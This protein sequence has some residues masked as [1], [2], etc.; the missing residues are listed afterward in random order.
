[1][2]GAW[3]LWVG[4]G[5]QQDMNWQ[6]RPGFSGSGA[7]H[8]PKIENSS[9]KYGIKGRIAIG[10]NSHRVNE[11]D[12]IAGERVDTGVTFPRGLAGEELSVAS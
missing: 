3:Q 12:N 1:M 11:A 6:N 5:G 8:M 10:N 7:N 2:D 9:G 4:F